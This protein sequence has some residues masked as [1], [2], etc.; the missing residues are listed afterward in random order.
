MLVEELKTAAIQLNGTPGM[1]FNQA[2]K[3]IFEVI[4]GKSIRTTVKMAGNSPNG[5]GISINRGFAFTLS[6]ECAKMFLVQ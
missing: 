3:V 1:G 2:G 6:L 4:D 5:P